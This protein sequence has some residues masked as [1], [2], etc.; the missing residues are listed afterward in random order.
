MWSAN[1]TVQSSLWSAKWMLYSCFKIKSEGC[2]GLPLKDEKIQENHFR[3]FFESIVFPLIWSFWRNL[4]CSTFLINFQIHFGDVMISSS[5]YLIVLDRFSQWFHLNSL[6]QLVFKQQ[7]NEIIQG[8]L[9]KDH[10]RVKCAHPF[11]DLNTARVQSSRQ[12]RKKKVVCIGFATHFFILYKTRALILKGQW[13]YCRTYCS[14]L[15]NIDCS[16]LREYTSPE[17]KLRCSPGG[18]LKPVPCPM[19]LFKSNFSW[20]CLLISSACQVHRFITLLWKPQCWCQ[21]LQQM[22]T[23]QM[24]LGMRSKTRIQSWSPPWRRKESGMKEARRDNCRLAWA[25]SIFLSSISMAC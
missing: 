1:C 7:V 6:I 12:D 17:A 21:L 19:S 14:Y 16:R 8:T 2:G 5:C 10:F 13:C 18:P 9:V 4:C 20:A 11:E 23:L 24:S 3:G 22:F 25:T 15:C